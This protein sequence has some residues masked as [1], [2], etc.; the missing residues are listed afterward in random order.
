MWS[1]ALE[2]V[3]CGSSC[4]GFDPGGSRPGSG[5]CHVLSHHPHTWGILG[6][7]PEVGGHPAAPP[8]CCPQ[9]VEIKA[10]LGSTLKYDT[11]KEA[12]ETH[13]PAVLFLCQV[14][15]MSGLQPG[16][17]TARAH[18]GTP[19]GLA[20]SDGNARSPAMGC[21]HLRELA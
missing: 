7:M 14:G 2:L 13:K 3:G 6:A 21:S 16:W 15:R 1:Q 17:P 4:P 18:T 10:E 8:A 12:V 11:I 20:R 9:V 5:M 19:G